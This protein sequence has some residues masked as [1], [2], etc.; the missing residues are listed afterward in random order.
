MKRIHLNT[1]TPATRTM[2]C[3]GS[4][5]ALFESLYKNDKYGFIYESLSDGAT[6]GKYSFLGSKPYLIFKGLADEAEITFQNNLI[7]LK[8]NP[9]TLLEKL[10][11]QVQNFADVKPYPGGPLAVC[12]T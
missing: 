6:R 7:K 9:L 4:P 11:K 1:Y 3:K 10:T 5:L 2:T 12:R 8:G